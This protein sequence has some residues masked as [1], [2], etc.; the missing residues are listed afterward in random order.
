[1]PVMSRPG[2]AIY[3]ETNGEISSGMGADVVTLVNGHTRSSSD[4]RMMSR[5]LLDAGIPSILIDNR[6]AGKTEVTQPFSISD[7]CSDVVAVWDEL[8]V[9]QSILLGISM[10]GFIC[11]G[12]AIQQPS[13]VFKLIL[14]SSAPDEGYINPSG[15]GWI[16]EGDELEKKMKFYFAPGFVDR[17]PVLFTTM[18]SQIRQ[19]IK[20][21]HF[22]ERSDMQRR[23]LRGSS[24]TDQLNEIKA[25]TLIIHGLQD[26]VIDISAAHALNKLITN[27]KLSPIEGAGHL[28]LAEAPKILY[29]KIVSFIL[30]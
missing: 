15:G 21:G 19:A 29:D 14:V 3:Y 11:Q 24:W 7:M 26:Q 16:A 17:N 22:T 27:S 5:V 10:G 8:G 6:G 20:Q 28:L 13:R 12:V 30:S 23:A 4:F 18:V 25:E 2:A 9:R 1:M